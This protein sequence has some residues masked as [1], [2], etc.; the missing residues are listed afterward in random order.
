MITQEELQKLFA[1]NEIV[2]L[3]NKEKFF[4]DAASMHLLQEH[5][6]R[7]ARDMRCNVIIAE[8]QFKAKKK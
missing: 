7:I 5:V 6:E 1:T 8:F 4:H 2:V 3:S